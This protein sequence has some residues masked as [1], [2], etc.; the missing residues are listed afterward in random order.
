[1]LTRI[2]S[3]RGRPR[4]R[5]ASHAVRRSL[6]AWVD[7]SGWAAATLVA[8]G[9]ATGANDDAGGRESGRGR[10]GLRR[11]RGQGHARTHAW[12]VWTQVTALIADT[13]GRQH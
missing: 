5:H 12:E 3:R 9:W 4:R 2:T 1:M 8:A 6:G 10:R 11:A 13:L 7:H